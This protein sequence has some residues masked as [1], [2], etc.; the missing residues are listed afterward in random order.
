MK[1]SLAVLLT[2]VLIA[3]LACDRHSPRLTP[4]AP[5]A[6]AELNQVT[7][8]AGPVV[9]SVAIPL[10]GWSRGGVGASPVA[11]PIDASPGPLGKLAYAQDGALWVKALPDGVP[12]RLV[13][14]TDAAPRWSPSG[15][16]LLVGESVVRAD[17]SGQRSAGGCLAWSPV[18]DEL[19]CVIKDQGLIVESA[20]GAESHSIALGATPSSVRWSP[21]GRKLAYVVDSALDTTHTPYSRTSSLWIVNADG[22]DARALF[23]TDEVA[24]EG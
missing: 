20:D 3:G 7:A 22:S 21:D 23:L 2:A 13:A 19:A 12:R 8:T 18:A 6:I 24:T 11:Q 16:W 17:G 9:A 15:D 1:Y 4:T 5:A 14:G 10:G